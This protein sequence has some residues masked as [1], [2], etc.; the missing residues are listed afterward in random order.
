MVVAPRIAGRQGSSPVRR[1]IALLA[2]VGCAQAGMPP[3]GPPDTDPPQLVRVTPDTNALN[4]R[5][6]SIAFQFNEVVSERPR[7]VPGLAE[8]FIVSPSTGPSGISW[9][10]TRVE[11]TPRGGLRPNTTYTVRMLPGLVDLDNN[12]DS[13]GM[14][15]VFSTGASLATGRISGR[16]FDWVAGRAA[17]RAI[18]E[19][20]SLPDSARYGTEADSSGSFSIT[21][22][23][24]G[25]FLLRV[26]IDQNRNASLDARE[27][28]DTITVTLS[29]SLSRD[30]LAAVRDT[31]GPGVLT[32]DLRDSLT[33]RLTL[34]H[35]L[36]TAFVPTPATISIKAADS[37]VVSFASVLTQAE[38]DRAIADSVRRMQVQDSVRRAFIADS[39]RQADSVRTAS[40]RA[41]PMAAQPVPPGQPS[42]P[43]GRR[44]GVTTRAPTAPT[45]RDTTTRVPARPDAKLPVTALYVKFERPL[46]PGGSFRVEVKDLRSITGATRTSQRVFTTPRARPDTGRVKPDTG[47]LT[48]G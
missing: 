3:G 38:L 47:R 16:A 27:L 30:M 15:V 19:A 33:L 4:V 35:P 25:Q 17:P 31:I 29:D 28:F 22:M 9:R 24:P 39:A 18:V 36:D 41:A 10:R 11:I 13:S 8:L 2:V 26:L 23:P 44:P 34:D 12:A 21:H 40:E 48:R 5:G 14:T 20:I 6:N 1:L 37:S 42:R 43:T 46:P 32:A 45:T 7:G